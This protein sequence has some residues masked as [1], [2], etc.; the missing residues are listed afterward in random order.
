MSDWNQQIIDEFRSMGGR[1]SGPFEGKPLLLLHHRGAKTGVE[2]VN[3][4]MYRRERDAYVVFASKAGADTNPAWYHNL[5]A[6]PE[7]R[8][9]VGID[10][11]AVVAREV[12]GDERHRLWEA[13][14]A[15]FAQFADYERN[16]TRE[17]PVI[18]LDPV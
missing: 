6:N 5:M 3:P 16:T 13:Q 18:V 7:C 12:H 4:L 9:E 10:E 14:K 2:R 1:V 8:I 15:E 17:I 11:H